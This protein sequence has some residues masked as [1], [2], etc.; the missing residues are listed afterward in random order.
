MASD[1]GVHTVIKHRPNS[2]LSVA[3]G[4]E[5]QSCCYCCR[6]R[7]HRVAP[8]PGKYP[9][10]EI[11]EV[12]PKRFLRIVHVNPRERDEDFIETYIEYLERQRRRHELQRKA[13]NHS[14]PGA[15]L[16][17]DYAAG[18]NT[19]T[20]DS[21]C[22][23]IN[24][25]QKAN[26][27][28]HLDTARLA[29]NL[30]INTN[31]DDNKAEIFK[32]GEDDTEHVFT[33]DATE[34]I[35]AGDG[36]ASPMTV[37]P[38]QLMTSHHEHVLTSQPMPSTECFSRSSISSQTSDLPIDKS[39]NSTAA[40]LRNVGVDIQG[41][42]PSVSFQGTSEPIPASREQSFVSQFGA[43]LDSDAVIFFFHGVGGSASV[44]QGQVDYFRDLGYELVVVDM[45]GHGFSAVPE[46]NDGYEF[47]QIAL[48]ALAVFD[49]YCKKT[50][51]I[52]GHS[53]G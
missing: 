50:N 8:L 52:I 20:L 45:I 39:R 51:V 43:S 7:H 24:L 28:E 14:I 23:V 15:K 11:V 1:S 30:R 34:D 25:N 2:T 36:D 46:K 12:R 21:D 5:K 9:G 17:E 31:D 16:S 32:H 33:G 35:V 18:A 22:D 47:R 10:Y 27:A 29:D 6:L 53:Y 42:R 26:P 41:K 19:D 40:T 37:L 3:T 49:L 13:M 38:G 4:E 48:D 44:W